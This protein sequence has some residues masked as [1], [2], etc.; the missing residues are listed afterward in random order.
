MSNAQ[1]VF[2]KAL[3][4]WHRQSGRHDLPWQKNPTPYRV[5]VSE[6]MLQQTQ[7]ST[8]Q[9][10][11]V[12]WMQDF[13]DIKTLASAS[14]DAVLHHWSG[15]GYYARARNLHSAARTIKENCGGELPDTLDKLMALPGI[16]R[17]TAGAILALS[18]GQRHAILDGNV[19][20]V[21]ARF[22]AVPGWPGKREVEKRLWSLAEMHTPASDVAAYTQAIMDLG[23]T[24]C[25][26]TKPACERCPLAQSCAAHVQGRESAFPAPRP[27]KERPVKHTWMALLID[28]D[29]SVCLERRPPTGIWGGLWGFPEFPS[30]G[31][32]RDE[33]EEA[34]AVNDGFEVW[35]V[36]SHAFTH[37]QLEITPVLLRLPAAKRGVAASDGQRWIKAE[38]PP[39]LGLA[40]PVAGLLDRLAVQLA[41]AQVT[42]A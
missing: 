2:A 4:A 15:L 6:I 11:F 42:P 10:Y 35:P 16:G 33:F 7:V 29:G 24:V 30:L 37:Y 13:P 23:A 41:K 5:W 12:R 27:R 19:R 39:R 36:V 3:L 25:T 9:P 31:A 22:H 32:L 8:V 18:L 20:R 1:D 14:I 21:L 26:R 28:A 34:G 40:A 38:A 17:S